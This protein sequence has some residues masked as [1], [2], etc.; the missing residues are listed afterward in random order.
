M[1][2][3]GKSFVTNSPHDDKMPQLVNLHTN[4]IPLQLLKP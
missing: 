4:V 3:P 2:K 1:T